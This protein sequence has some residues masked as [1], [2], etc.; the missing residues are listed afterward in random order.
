M[1]CNLW[2][3]AR[4]RARGLRQLRD[5]NLVEIILT[6]APA[7]RRSRQD[8]RGRST[9]FGAAKTPGGSA[10]HGPACLSREDLDELDALVVRLGALGPSGDPFTVVSTDMEFHQVLC[11]RS[12][13][14]LLIDALRDSTSRRVSHPQHTLVSL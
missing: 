4:H 3:V 1:L 9:R 5:E 11:E 7:S 14:T 6:E 10:H 13:H 2:R 8:A 12:E